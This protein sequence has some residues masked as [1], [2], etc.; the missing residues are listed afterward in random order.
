MSR[1]FPFYCS[2]WELMWVIQVGRK[3]SPGCALSNLEPAF[4]LSLT[5]SV[6]EL[7]HNMKH[8]HPL[9]ITRTLVHKSCNICSSTTWA[10]STPCLWC[11]KDVRKY[12]HWILHCFL[13]T[14]QQGPW[15]SAVARDPG[16]CIMARVTCSASYQ[17]NVPQSKNPMEEPATVVKKWAC[18]MSTHGG[19]LYLVALSPLYLPSPDISYG[20]FF[21]KTHG[22]FLIFRSS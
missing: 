12:W 18:P 22:K 3:L 14:S 16:V 21:S 11:Q 13:G 6:F 5:P 1:F 9:D 7:L 19:G 2:F 4:Y 8:R 20:W 10:A 15:I 17:Q